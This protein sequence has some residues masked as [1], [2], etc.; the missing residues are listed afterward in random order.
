MNEI[1]T[2]NEIQNDGRYIHLYYNGLVG[3]YAAYG[4][5]AY[6]LCKEMALD[7]VSYSHNLLMPVVAINTMHLEELVGRLTVTSSNNGYYCL[8]VDNPLDENE[9]SEWANRIIEEV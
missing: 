1:I 9:Y 6:N 4:Y 2:L 7:N 8:K 5:S 3:L